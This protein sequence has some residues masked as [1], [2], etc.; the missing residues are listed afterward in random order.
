M[1]IRLGFLSHHK[2]IPLFQWWFDWFDLLFNKRMITMVPTIPIV[3]AVFGFIF[4]IILVLM[5]RIV[6]IP[7]ILLTAGITSRVIVAW[8]IPAG[9]TAAARMGRFS[10]DRS[11]F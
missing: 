9:V 3:I 8:S 2:I 6:M 11:R 10:N 4:M 5:L 1:I 7:G